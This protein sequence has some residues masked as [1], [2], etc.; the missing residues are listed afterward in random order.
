MWMKRVVRMLGATW[1]LG[2]VQA[3]VMTQVP[4]MLEMM[5]MMRLL[6]ELLWCFAQGP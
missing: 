1:M 5:M 3:L 4:E 6:S 2:M